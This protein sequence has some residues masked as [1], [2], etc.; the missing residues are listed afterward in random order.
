MVILG[1]QSINI[2]RLKSAD[3]GHVQI[4]QLGRYVI[5]NGVDQFH[6]RQDGIAHQTVIH[7]GGGTD[8]IVQRVLS[9]VRV[10]GTEFEHSRHCY[11]RDRVL[12]GR[13]RYHVGTA[14]GDE[15]AVGLVLFKRAISSN[16]YPLQYK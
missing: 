14:G 2:T 1:E 8:E 6:F 9:F 7:H 15:T 13:E 12:F 3:I 4:D 11:D 10:H 5:V 16:T